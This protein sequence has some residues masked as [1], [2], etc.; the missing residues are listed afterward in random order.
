MSLTAIVIAL[1]A[2]AA[3][4]MYRLDYEKRPLVRLVLSIAAAGCLCIAYGAL[5]A[6]GI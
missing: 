6:A 3:A 1:L 2:A 5:A 4:I